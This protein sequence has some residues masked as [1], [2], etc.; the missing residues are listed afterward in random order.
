MG[1]NTGKV[2]RFLSQDKKCNEV[3]VH[4]NMLEGREQLAMVEAAPRCFIME[5]KPANAVPYT[6]LLILS[7]FSPFPPTSPV[8]IVGKVQIE[9]FGVAVDHRLFEREKCLSH[10]SFHETHLDLRCSSRYQH[11]ELRLQWTDH[12]SRMEK[13]RM[14]RQLYWEVAGWDVD[15]KEKVKVYLKRKMEKNG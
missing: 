5:A 8:I 10:P 6:E 15:G 7:P 13:A 3:E 14:P 4:S 1:V 12:L 9:W 2:L 11:T